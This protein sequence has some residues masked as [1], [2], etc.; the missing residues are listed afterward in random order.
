MSFNISFYEMS[1]VKVIKQASSHDDF[2]HENTSLSI[3]LHNALVL[4]A[5]EQN[6][7]TSNYS[8]CVIYENI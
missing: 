8:T 3:F 2:L 4:L 6:D 7:I 5:I 1:L